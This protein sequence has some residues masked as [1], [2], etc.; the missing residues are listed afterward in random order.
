MVIDSLECVL[1]QLG[2]A[3]LVVAIYATYRLVRGQKGCVALLVEYTMPP[4]T[5]QR[6]DKSEFPTTTDE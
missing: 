2:I 4:S 3:S 5:Q 1:A 6:C